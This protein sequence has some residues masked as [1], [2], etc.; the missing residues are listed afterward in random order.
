VGQQ[1]QQQQER[2]Q[3]AGEAAG[4]AAAGRQAGREDCHR[5]GCVYVSG[6][7]EWLLLKVWCCR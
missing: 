6:L 7:P 1:Q 5:M 4:R 2:Q 3:Q